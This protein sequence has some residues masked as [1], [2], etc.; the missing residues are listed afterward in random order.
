MAEGSAP[1][2]EHINAI[3]IANVINQ[4]SG[5]VVIA[6]W[7]V[8]HIPNNWIETFLAMTNLPSMKSVV[9]EQKA[10]VEKWKRDH[11]TYRGK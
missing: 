2:N 10:I 9:D 11:P 5:G 4:Y 8:D 3:N 6:P 7:E 1:N